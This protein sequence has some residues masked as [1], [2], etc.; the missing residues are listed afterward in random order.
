[1]SNPRSK[2]VLVNI[3]YLIAVNKFYGFLDARIGPKSVGYIIS[4]Y[5][6][7]NIKI[8]K[9]E[10]SQGDDIIRLLRKKNLEG[11]WL[12]IYVNEEQH[13]P[14]WKLVNKKGKVFDSTSKCIKN[15][16]HTSPNRF[17]FIPHE[18]P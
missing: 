13:L 8:N 9:R 4:I 10:R 2:E 11:K 6:E 12:T 7:I 14:Y 16:T 3:S 1:M 18:F 15:I 17:I 5:K